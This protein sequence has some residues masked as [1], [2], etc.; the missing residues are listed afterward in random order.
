MAQ[1]AGQTNPQAATLGVAL[2][3]GRIIGRTRKVGK[4]G[5]PFFI[6]LLRLPA[7]DEY[8]SPGTVEVRSAASVGDIGGDAHLRVRIGGYGRSYK[9]TDENGESKTVQTADNSLTVCE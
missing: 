9:T 4:D 5:K 7:P 3:K 6:T 2:L 8:T 1:D